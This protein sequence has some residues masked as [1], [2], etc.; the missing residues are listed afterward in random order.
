MVLVDTIIKSCK[1]LFI[2]YKY[3]NGADSLVG[4]SLGLQNKD[5]SLN[6]NHPYRKPVVCVCM[7]VTPPLQ[8]QTSGVHWS[9]S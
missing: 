1:S 8:E 2:C 6:S 4:K 9:H 7:P 5:A 3:K